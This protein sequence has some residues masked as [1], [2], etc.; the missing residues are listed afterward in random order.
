M[1]AETIACIVYVP[2]DVIKERLQVQSLTLTNSYLGSFHAMKQIMKTEGF[3]GIYKGYWATLASFGPYSAIYFVLYEKF[4]DYARH[5]QQSKALPT[6]ELSLPLLLLS[7]SSAGAIASWLTSPLDMA[8]LRM[9]IQRGAQSSSSPTEITYRG[10]IH[11]LQMTLK[12]QGIP[13]LFRGA[14][15][16]V[17]HFVPSMTIVMTAYEKCRSFYANLLA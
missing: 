15:A 14:G 9:Q 4:K 8:K 13:G 10:F 6:Q 17:L 16:R 2:V 12:Q 3:S 11:C 1:L 7:S 5:Y